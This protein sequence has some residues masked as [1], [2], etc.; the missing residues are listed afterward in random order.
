M[1]EGIFKN[2]FFASSSQQK[3]PVHI[4]GVLKQSRPHACRFVG[5]LAPAKP[6]RIPTCNYTSANQKSDK[7]RNIIENGSAITPLMSKWKG[8]VVCGLTTKT[9][10]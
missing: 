4:A 5:F 3:V 9:V 2:T 8:G 1:Y 10:I 7:S 6:D